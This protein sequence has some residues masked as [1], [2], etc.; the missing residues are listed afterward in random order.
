MPVTLLDWLLRRYPTAKRQTLKRMVSDG[1]VRIN[2]IPARTLKQP[3]EEEDRIIVRPNE[4]RP[5]DRVGIEPLR[6]I[7]ED[8]DLL[9]VDKP[10]GLLTSTVAREKR[11]TALAIIRAYLR[12]RAAGA[13][14]GVIHRLDRDASGLLVFSK[15]AE[16]Y[17]S[18]KSQFYHRTARRVYLAI[19]S[20]RPTTERGK[21]ES[22]LVEWVDGT[23]HS[24]RQAGKGEPAITH[25]ELI[26]QRQDR[27]LLR[28]TL[29]TGRKHQIRAHLSERGWPIVGDRLYGG[30][31]AARLM[32]AAVELSFDRPHDGKR[33]EFQIPSPL[34]F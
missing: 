1:R 16:A 27:Y 13:R 5:V 25:Y 6:L 30:I 4:P 14:V 15:S 34:P 29:Q 23:V 7:H 31:P 24:T 22:N 21:I 2:D 17:E 33:L 26:D 10:A 20:N 3:V 8:G 32:L 28:I 9:V 11:P 18:L 12:D 19:T